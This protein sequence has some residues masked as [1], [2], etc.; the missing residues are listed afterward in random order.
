MLLIS[1]P[2]GAEVVP[3]WNEKVPSWPPCN[4]CVQ[5]PRGSPPEGAPICPPVVFELGVPVL[6]I[7]YGLQVI[8]K[9]FGGEVERS[10]KREYGKAV[11]KIDEG[12]N[13]LSDVRNNTVIWMSHG[14]HL[15]KLPP[16]F[17]LLAHTEDIP[18]A[19]IGNEKRN[20]YGLQFHPEVA[21]TEEGQNILQNFLFRICDCRGSWTTESFIDTTVASIR[22]QVKDGKVILGLSGGVDSSVCAV[23]INRAV[24]KQLYSILVDNGLLRKNEAEAVVSAFRDFGLN[25]TLVDAS[26]RFLTQLEGVMDPEEKRKIIGKT[27]IQVFEEEA[28]KIKNVQFLA[29]GTL[30]P[31]VIEST[32]FKGP[33][34]T[35]KSHHN[36]G[37]LPEEMNL[38]LTKGAEALEELF[39]KNGIGFV[40]DTARKNVA[41]KSG[42]FR[43]R[44]D[45]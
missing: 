45:G 20:I 17:D 2:S 6:G 18:I 4:V 29:Q 28:H 32:S 44:D 42:W 43:W 5:C 9:L 35:I 30:Y 23:L 36:V 8:G 24:G 12:E 39:D 15:S 19:A 10:E 34:A 27:F 11:I 22:D 26:E 41:K 37:G 7:C 31:D 14:D 13:L 40:V 1:V 25:L 33:S 21:H 38:K 16:Q 3:A